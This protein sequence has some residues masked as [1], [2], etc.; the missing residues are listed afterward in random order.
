MLKK[1]TTHAEYQTQL[2]FGI[3]SLTQN[4][5][6]RLFKSFPKSLLKLFLLNLDNL[7]SVV[8]PL[9]PELGRPAKNQC[10][11]IRS[12]VLMVDTKEYS[13]TDWVDKTHSDSLIQI[14]CG[15]NNHIPGLASYYDLLH[16]LWLSKKPDRIKLRKFKRKPNKHYKANQK[17]P[18]RRPGVVRRLVNAL[19]QDS[20]PD[21][22]P[23]R[24]LQEILK[25]A[26]VKPSAQLGLLG[27]ID[28]F[29]IAVDGS[30]YYADGSSPY[31]VKVCNCKAEGN[32]HCDCPRKYSDPDASWG[33]DSYR[34]QWFYGN[35]LFAVTAANSQNDLPIYLHMAQA[36]RHDGVSTVF[37]VRNVINMFPKITIKKFLA[38]GAMDDYSIYEMLLKRNIQP[39]IP[40]PE[41]TKFPTLEYYP[42]ISSFD[43]HGRPICPAGYCWTHWGFDAKKQR[44]K[45]RCPFAAKGEPIP[46]SWTC[47]CCNKGKSAY[48][49]SFYLKSNN[50]IRLF[51]PVPVHILFLDRSLR[52]CVSSSQY[53]CSGTV[54]RHPYWHKQYFSLSSLFWI[55]CYPWDRLPYHL[56]LI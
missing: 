1:W 11:I 29:T 51:P 8:K 56:H 5:K 25:H 2:K 24:I 33:W 55:E 7:F 34:E 32:Y 19:Q 48:G 38:D 31:G 53:I 14:L 37:A 49:P 17:L 50:D 22:R 41:N 46:N 52:S 40:L 36:S 30:P 20:L 18:N 13:I 6:N 35:T 28:D 54:C 47:T 9:Y 15:F 23:E 43:D 26:V 3:A 27:D 42:E 39:F 21:I 16:R 4:D 45:Y 44:H 10:E 12:L